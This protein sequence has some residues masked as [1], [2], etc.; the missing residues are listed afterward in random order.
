MSDLLPREPVTPPG[1]D[2]LLHSE[3]LARRQHG[4][5]GSLSATI[6]GPGE[7]SSRSLRRRPSITSIR[8]SLTILC[9]LSLAFALPVNAQTICP[10]MCGTNDNTVLGFAPWPDATGG[11]NASGRH[12]PIQTR[13]RNSPAPAGASAR[14]HGWPDYPGR[15]RY[16]GRASRLPV[17]LRQ[18]IFGWRAEFHRG[19]M[20]H[21]RSTWAGVGTDVFP[22]RAVL[23][24]LRTGPAPTVMWIEEE[25]L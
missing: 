1:K 21:S 25:G 14:R 6:A 8:V 4:A 18:S 17:E 19:A 12:P 20:Q 2:T 7:Q 10:S 15:C 23:M 11:G 5:C 13:A 24:D 9:A 22:W 16:I 3:S